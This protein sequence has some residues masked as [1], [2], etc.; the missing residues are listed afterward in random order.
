MTPSD[1]AKE[2]CRNAFIKGAC[3][4]LGW[5]VKEAEEF[6][7]GGGKQYYLDV[8]RG[9]LTAIL[10]WSTEEVL[11]WSEKWMDELNDSE[12]G[13]YCDDPQEYVIVEFVPKQLWNRLAPFDKIDLCRDL[14]TALDGDIAFFRFSQDT[15][16]SRYREPIN[17]VLMEYELRFPNF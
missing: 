11:Q 4:H 1:E 9:L 3:D 17:K 7:D 12:N 14:V 13:I 15:D 2:R 8:W 6:A 16:W 10:N 5:S